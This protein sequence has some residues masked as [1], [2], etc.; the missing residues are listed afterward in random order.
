MECMT[1]KGN[2]VEIGTRFLVNDTVK[3]V[4]SV[5]ELGR[6]EPERHNKKTGTEP[7]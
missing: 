6:S 1:V 3:F 2:V 4:L 5:G 7:Q